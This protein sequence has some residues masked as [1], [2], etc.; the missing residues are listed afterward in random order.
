MLQAYVGILSQRGV[1]AVWPEGPHS[2]RFLAR[3][4]R[5]ERSV[6][7]FWTVI[8]DDAAADLQDA[9]ITGDSIAALEM[10]QSTAHDFGIMLPSD[11]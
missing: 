10:L 4:I 3:R 8:S 1:E 6:A 11:E 5:R 9:L 2:A 7:C